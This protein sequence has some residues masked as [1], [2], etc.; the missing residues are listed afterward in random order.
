MFCKPENGLAVRHRCRRSAVGVHQECRQFA[1]E[2]GRIVRG[3]RR[4]SAADSAERISQLA[5]RVRKHERDD[6]FVDGHEC[7]RA[8]RVPGIL[9]TRTSRQRPALGCRFRH[10]GTAIAIAAATLHRREHTPAANTFLIISV[11]FEE[12]PTG[13]GDTTRA[14]GQIR[15]F[16]K[17]L[18]AL[19]AGLAHPE[20]QQG[21]SAF[22][23]REQEAGLE[24][25][26]AACNPSVPV[27]AQQ[28]EES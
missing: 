26:A 5:A 21:L 27:P 20:L 23:Q 15:D 13:T 7:F 2:R 16:E 4:F 1:L 11:P 8:I 10:T 9:R 24:Q 14:R 17:K 3:R 22:Q 25:G 28:V 12:M 19:W 18:M 6:R